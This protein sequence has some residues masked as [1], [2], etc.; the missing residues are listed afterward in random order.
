MPSE[1][2][3]E[4]GVE[5][6]DSAGAVPRSAAFPLP[7]MSFVMPYTAFPLEGRCAMWKKV[8]SP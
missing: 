2:S 8:N 3:C 6:A 5:Q 1:Y 7:L 4:P